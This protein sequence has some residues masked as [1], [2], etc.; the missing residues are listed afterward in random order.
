[1]ADSGNTQGNGRWTDERI[2]VIISNLLRFG[3]GLSALVVLAGA[4]YYLARHG[5]EEAG[6]HV[7]RGEPPQLHTISGIISFALTSHSRGLIELGLLLL[8][9][10]PVARVL[11][12]AVA[13]A[14]QRD[15]AYVIITL[16]VLAIL[17]YNL[18][19]G[20]RY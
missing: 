5:G 18:I 1:M 3:V 2:D 12:S 20:Y 14:L 8:I 16:I 15:R 13:F 17:T 19:A 4:V 9:L 6:F 10:T 11:L 7:F